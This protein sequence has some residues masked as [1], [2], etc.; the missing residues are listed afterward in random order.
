MRVVFSGLAL[1]LAISFHS[2]VASPAS[3]LTKRAV[4]CPE[5]FRNVVF[6][7]GVSTQPNWPGRYSF[8]QGYGINDWI[9]FTI[10]QDPKA[11]AVTNEHQ[12]RIVMSP[13]QVS[14]AIDIVTSPTAPA[15]LEYLNEPDSNFNPG[16]PPTTAE[17]AAAAVQP[18]LA[19]DTQTKFLSPAPAYTGSTYLKDFFAA[20][21]AKGTPN[22]L[23]RFHAISVHAYDADP[24]KVIQAIE[25]VHA[26]FPGKPIWVTESSPVSSPD[27]GCELSEQGVI[28]WMNRAVGWAAGSGYVERWF[29]NSG[30]DGTVYE[31]R[32][33]VC[34]PSLTTLDSK[35]TPL[36]EAYR[37]LCA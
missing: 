36:L 19:A 18:L 10:D 16:I 30:E 1:S 31:G 27:Q 23:D 3:S 20:C 37:A 14:H 32:P 15:Y 12:L 29:W 25:G 8:L 17:E 6:N 26:Q 24:E 5:N 35:E 21:S 33:E 22:C 13:T 28:D 2:V 7:G 34:N 4:T 9:G 11:D